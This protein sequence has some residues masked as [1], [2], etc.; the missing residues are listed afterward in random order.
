MLT[1]DK[2]AGN[3]LTGWVVPGI[4]MARARFRLLCGAAGTC[5]VDAKGEG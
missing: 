3:L 5:D 4:E 2:P 1:W